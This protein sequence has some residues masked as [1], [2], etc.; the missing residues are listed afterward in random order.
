M[1]VSKAN[2]G[3]AFG[4]CVALETIMLRGLNKDVSFADSPLLSKESLLYMI[5]NCASDVSFTITL[6]PDVYAKCN[7]DEYEGGWYNDVNGAL[8]DAGDSRG[9]IITLAEA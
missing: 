5:D 6:H 1:D 3:S 2:L 8:L 4:G 9:T 7:L